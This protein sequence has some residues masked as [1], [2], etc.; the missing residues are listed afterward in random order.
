MASC[1]GA[2]RQV[3]TCILGAGQPTHRAAPVA[4]APVRHVHQSIAR[5]TQSRQAL[6]SW[7][8]HAVRSDQQGAQVDSSTL[9]LISDLTA[10]VDQ[11]H[12]AILAENARDLEGV[13]D[14]SSEGLK[15]KV[16]QSIHKLQKGLLE[17]ETEVCCSY[18]L[19][20][21]PSCVHMLTN[22][23]MACVTELH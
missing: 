3:P 6:N 10:K 4:H 21:N 16:Q 14:T 23:F 9:Q 15:A 22:V 11:D 19:D 5:K 12:A 20:A 18:P 17:R 7:I 13:V 1:L 8:L 2:P